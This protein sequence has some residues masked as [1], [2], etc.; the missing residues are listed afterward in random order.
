[1]IERNISALQSAQYSGKSQP[2]KVQTS[3]HPKHQRTTE[4][5]SQPLDVPTVGSFHLA[6]IIRC[7]VVT[8]FQKGDSFPTGI[9][10]AHLAN[11]EAF[12]M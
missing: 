8:F 12:G 2:C 5:D 4:V 1:M 9:H 6:I 10:G 11:C 3:H 7:W